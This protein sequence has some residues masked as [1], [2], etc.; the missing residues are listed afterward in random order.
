MSSHYYAHGAHTHA[1][2]AHQRTHGAH[3]RIRD[4]RK[5]TRQA[6]V[7]WRGH[8]PTLRPEWI[9]LSTVM[10]LTAACAS[11]WA[12]ESGV[13]QHEQLRH[14]AV[15]DRAPASTQVPPHVP[16]PRSPSP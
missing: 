1:R 6:Q 16:L 5:H 13:P 4:A 3:E 8:R 15:I 14:G 12:I 11:A 7:T 2:G 10:V 9:A